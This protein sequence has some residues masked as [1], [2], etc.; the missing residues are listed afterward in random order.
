MEILK[1]ALLRNGFEYVGPCPVCGGRGFKYKRGRADATIK[2]DSQ[3]REVHIT[4]QG[5]RD[6]G[7]RIAITLIQAKNPL[8]VENLDSIL[9]TNLGLNGNQEEASS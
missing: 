4:L 5:F 2:K 9:Q 8:H 6:D 1:D 7:K 3:M